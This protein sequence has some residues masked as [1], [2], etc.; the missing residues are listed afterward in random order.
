MHNHIQSD[1][2]STYERKSV[3]PGL[4]FGAQNRLSFMP[5]MPNQGMVQNRPTIGFM[6]SR[7]FGSN[8]PSSQPYSGVSNKQQTFGAGQF[9]NKQSP[10]MQNF[11][12][13]DFSKPEKFLREI[14]EFISQHISLDKQETQI[15]PHQRNQAKQ[16]Q[17]FAPSNLSF[18]KKGGKFSSISGTD[19][20]I[21]IHELLKLVFDERVLASGPPQFKPAEINHLFGFLKYPFQI[22]NDAIT[23]VGAPS[24]IGILVKAIYW[25]Y[26]L[27][28]AHQAQTD[29]A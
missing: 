6:P 17:N 9:P 21:L 24:S 1:Q 19:A 14:F 26:I 13:L 7:P 4:M 10:N 29:D 28:A 3:A 5:R 16:L 11:D 2:M 27:A 18:F 12:S 20:Q 22:R 15:S 8:M 23:A 25:L